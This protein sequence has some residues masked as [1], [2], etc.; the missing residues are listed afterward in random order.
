VYR[1]WPG[2]RRF[3]PYSLPVQPRLSYASSSQPYGHPGLF[4]FPILPSGA[5]LGTCSGT[6]HGMPWARATPYAAAAYTP[7]E[8]TPSPYASQLPP[9]ILPHTDPMS[10]AS[11]GCCLGT[12]V[13]RLQPSPIWPEHSMTGESSQLLGPGCTLNASDGS[14]GPSFLTGSATPTSLGSDRI[15]PTPA[16]AQGDLSST[17]SSL[18]SLP[19][20]V[21]S[22]RSSHGWQTDASSNSSQVSGQTNGESRQDSGSERVNTTCEGPEMGFRYD[23]RARGPQSTVPASAPPVPGHDGQPQPPTLMSHGS[24]TPEPR[25]QPVS[26]ESIRSPLDSTALGYNYAATTGGCISSLRSTSGQLSVGTV[27]TQV[28]T[29]TPHRESVPE[30]CRLD[31]STCQTDTKHASLPS[32]EDSSGY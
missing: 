32:I 16:A 11:G 26:R 18:D 24:G 15:L 25:C 13:A 2:P 23:G 5:D 1:G 20:I 29:M 9:Y 6:T 10:N 3:T 21:L 28:H 12:H 8:E 19:L 30:D 22:H 31:C 17:I 27:Y 7:Y 14:G 4:H